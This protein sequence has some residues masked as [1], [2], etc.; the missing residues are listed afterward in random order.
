[1]GHKLKKILCIAIMMCILTGCSSKPCENCDD[2]P[3]KG[4][5]NS[6]SGEKEYY[7]SDCSSRCDLC[8]DKAEKNYT[9]Y[10]GIRFVC[11]DCYKE[12]KSYG[13]IS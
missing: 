12:L 8:G 4:Y 1:M 7:C 5:R 2:T 11:G 3:T 9:A 13:W 6:S 10:S